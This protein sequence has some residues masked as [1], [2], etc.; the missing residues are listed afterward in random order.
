MFRRFPHLLVAALIPSTLLIFPGIAEAAPSA[1]LSSPAC[2]TALS[3]LGEEQMK[4]EASPATLAAATAACSDSSVVLPK[5]QYA[6]LRFKDRA[7]GGVFTFT[8]PSVLELPNN[9]NAAFILLN[10]HPMGAYSETDEYMGSGAGIIEWVGNVYAA[11][12]TIS[13]GDAG[14]F[15]QVKIGAPLGGN[16]PSA[17]IAATRRYSQGTPVIIYTDKGPVRSTIGKTYKGEWPTVNGRHQGTVT[18]ANGQ[19]IGISGDFGSGL[20]SAEQKF[21]KHRSYL[22]RHTR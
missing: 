6:T 5:A 19:F 16:T 11:K 22:M 8:R 9:P 17:E 1:S 3:A 7:I 10:G 14:T 4:K 12:V 15:L 18:L 13:F 21:W 2:F 20:T